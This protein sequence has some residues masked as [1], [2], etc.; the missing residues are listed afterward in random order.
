[1]ATGL[2]TTTHVE[3]EYKELRISTTPMNYRSVVNQ[4]SQA[5]AEGWETTGVTFSDTGATVMI[6][7]RVKLP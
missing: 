7:K 3:W 1:L 6:M 2:K 5:G 4:L